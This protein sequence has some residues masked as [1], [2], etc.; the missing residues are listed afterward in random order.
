[1]EVSSRILSDLIVYSK[2]S[3]VVKGEARKETWTE[4]V[5]RNKKM[6]LK[7]YPLLQ[8]E[9]EETYKLVYDKKILPSMRSLQFAGKAIEVFNSR[10]NNC[11]YLPIDAP[12]AFQEIMFLLLGGSGVGFSVQKHHVNKL[13]TI[14]LPKKEKRFIVQD[15]IIGWSDAVKVLIKS[16]FTGHP[17]PRFDFS[18]IRE[19]GTP[20]KTSG[21]I[22]PGPEPL[23]DCLHNIQKILDRKETG[24]KLS[25]LECHDIACYIADCVLAGGIRR[26]ATIS[27]FS[28]NDEEMLAAK[29]G[30][31]YE[32][33]PQRG[34]ANNSAVI[35]RHKISKKD[36]LDFWEKIRHSGSGEPGYLLSNDQNVGTN[37]CGEVSL[38]PFVFCNLTEINVADITDQQ[39]L[40]ARAK[41]AA[42][43]GTLQAGYTDFHYL[44]EEW[45]TNTEK[46]ALIG[47]GMTGIATGRVMKLDLTQAAE[48]VKEENARVAKLIGINK[49]AR[50]TVVKPAGTSSIV[51]GCSSGIHAW[52]SKYYIRRIRVNKEEPIYKYLLKTI[53]SAVEDD[54]FKP[55]TDAVIS[56]PQ[57]A[58]P[59][60]ITREESAIDLLNRVAKVYDDWILPG[61]RNG[62]NTNN[63]SATISIKENEWNEV[64]E[65]MW[66]NRTR[67]TAL[68]VL[69]YDGHTYV[70][71]PFEEITREEYESRLGKL[72]D[73]DLTKLVETQQSNLASEVACSGGACEI[74]YLAGG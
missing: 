72:K 54:F 39:D 62:H 11:C 70:Q 69:P 27:L 18:D 23:K 42:F 51:L 10:I 15:S 6:H 29:A 36:F 55:T 58:P 71:P 7:K 33:N 67:Y 74:S 16:Y 59:T 63:V 45:K 52:H 57:K 46:D 31:W 37:P 24:D 13:P 68:S 43:I 28:F 3:L 56:L 65:W 38:K 5:D 64:G 8:E 30:K 40:N 41:A 35:L 21:G 60:A 47:V 44:R 66:A 26:A 20:L 4:I 50:C 49:A 61:H 19:K 1:M 9:I 73:I 22:A 34:R 32:L 17:R 25:P 48:V 14:I 53:P 12:E 2:Y